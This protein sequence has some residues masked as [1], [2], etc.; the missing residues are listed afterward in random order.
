MYYGVGCTGA[1]V[2]GGGAGLESP[3][4]TF[5]Y[6]LSVSGVV[7]TDEA[8]ARRE[9]G[10]RQLVYGPTNAPANVTVTRRVFVPEAGGFARFLETLVNTGQE[11]VT[12]EVRVDSTLDGDIQTLVA[13]AST[14]NTYAITLATPIISSDGNWIRPLLGH[15]FADAAGAATVSSVG[16]QRLSGTTHYAWTITIP[17]GGTAT[18][19]HFAVQGDPGNLAAAGA[20]AQS[21]ANLTDPDALAGMSAEDKARVVNFDIP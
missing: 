17:A 9:L 12:L 10:D 13:P 15:V 20:K 19:M 16:L 2:S 4:T 1:L 14:G 11:A 7:A 3:F 8:A 21:L 5:G 6:R 18:L